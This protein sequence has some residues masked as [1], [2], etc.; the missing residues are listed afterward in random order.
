M[1][2]RIILQISVITAI[3]GF[4]ALQS[5]K[6]DSVDKPVD[7]TPTIVKS[8]ISFNGFKFYASKSPSLEVKYTGGDSV[9]I[10]SG[11]GTFDTTLT[12][13]HNP[14]DIKVGT[15]SIDSTVAPDKGFVTVKLAWGNNISSP[16]LNFAKGNYEIKRENGK[17]VSYL[18][19]GEAWNGNNHKDRYYNIE[20]KVIWPY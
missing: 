6:K 5:C 10:W 7:T 12:I 16:F 9:L 18:K 20:F 2:K 13:G 3:C 4:F 14:N 19:N 17:Y 8:F 11:S 1:K 15:Y